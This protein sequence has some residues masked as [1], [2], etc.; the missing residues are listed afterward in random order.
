MIYD[1]HFTGLPFPSPRN[2][3]LEGAYS[4]RS[5]CHGA[6]AELCPEIRSL[7]ATFSLQRHVASLRYMDFVTWASGRIVT[8]SSVLV[9]TSQPEVQCMRGCVAGTA[10]H[11]VMSRVL[12][13]SR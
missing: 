2:D 1:D 13:H 7:T 11:C 3:V 8:D 10:E 12:N 6:L 9:T 5:L 4:L